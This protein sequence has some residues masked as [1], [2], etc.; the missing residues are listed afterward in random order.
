MKR[1]V[2]ASCLVLACGLWPCASAQTPAA[3]EKEQ[4]LRRL[5]RL[6]NPEGLGVQAVGAGR[7]SEMFASLPEE[8]RARVLNFIRDE[9]NKELGP[10]QM[11]ELSVPIYA[12]HLSDGEVKSLVEFYETPAGR[13]FLSVLPLISREMSQEIERKGKEAW[14]KIL[15]RLRAQGVSGPPAPQTEQQRPAKPRP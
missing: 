15:E 9:M 2:F 8:T 3:S 7:M 1:I 14:A 5:L 13:K 11:I 6:M 12:K 4:N 10:E